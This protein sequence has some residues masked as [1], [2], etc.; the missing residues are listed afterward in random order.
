MRAR[1]LLGTMVTIGVPTC[2]HEPQTF[3]AVQEALAIV[4]HV[5]RVMSAHDP[6]SDLGRMAMARPGEV[7]TVDAHT[8]AVLRA[9]QYWTRQSAG[10]FNPVRAAR[11]L[12]R[13]QRRA[14][15]STE[16]PAG[17]NLDDVTILADTQVKMAAAV[18]IDLGGI[19]KGYAVDRA[20]E[21][22]VRHGLRQAIVNAGGDI[23]AW[24]DK[25][26]AVDVRHAGHGLRD[27]ALAWPYRLR[28]QAMATS[29]AD[30]QATD[31]VRTSQTGRAGWTSATVIAPDCMS[32]DALTKWALQSSR[33]CPRLKAVLRE[34][35]A[36]MWRS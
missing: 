24:G 21:V 17:V 34:H 20:I 23:R 27:R 8:T 1:P 35:R 25:G 11:V 30:V 31:F 5:G 33:L 4:A 18:P 3:E 32:A 19:A 6:Q 15:L 7:L 13:Q 12:A 14:G 26:F 22:L 36:R 28:Q 16:T 9:A 2:A 10:A 29:V